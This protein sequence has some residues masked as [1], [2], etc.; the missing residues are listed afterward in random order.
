M[1]AFT[2]AHTDH[3]DLSYA[4][5]YQEKNLRPILGP[6]SFPLETCDSQKVKDVLV[7]S[8]PVR[9]LGRAEDVPH[10]SFLIKGSKTV[11]FTGDASP[12]Q[13]QKMALPKIDVLIG[14]YAYATSRTGWHT[15]RELAPETVVLL[16]FPLRENDPAGLWDSALKTVTE[17]PVG[18]VYIP[19][20]GQTVT[21]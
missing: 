3:F 19:H 15:V 1:V 2:H 11:L 7:Q 6:E 16:H 4:Q 20:M 13:W 21:V 5:D 12:L 10:V 17:S 8:L 9:H 18:T 14:T